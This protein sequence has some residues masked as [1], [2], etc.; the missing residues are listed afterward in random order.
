MGQIGE[1]GSGD[2]KTPPFGESGKEKESG[3]LKT[4][5]S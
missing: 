1:S 3:G 2:F 4:P 5:P